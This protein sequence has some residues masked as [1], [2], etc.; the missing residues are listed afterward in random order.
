[1]ESKTQ[2]SFTAG[3]LYVVKTDVKPGSPAMLRSLTG[4]RGA[5]VLPTG[6][7]VVPMGSEPMFGS[8]MAKAVTF[9]R[10]LT[11]YGMGWVQE[12]AFVRDVERA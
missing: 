4:S 6:T 5:L 2:D 7:I 12:S 10:V 9:V 3:T 1:M 11:P 8:T